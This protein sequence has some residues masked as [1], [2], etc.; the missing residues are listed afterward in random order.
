[1][2]LPK[3]NKNINSLKEKWII[4]NIIKYMKYMKNIYLENRL[5]Y[6]VSKWDLNNNKTYIYAENKKKVI[7]TLLH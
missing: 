7:K 6:I 3:L 4:Y 2:K 5:K 1:M